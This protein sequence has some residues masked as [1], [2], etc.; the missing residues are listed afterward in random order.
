MNDKDTPAMQRAQKLFRKEEQKKDGALAWNEYASQE[1]A[2]RLKTDRL[3]AL[4]LARDAE[5]AT[6]AP[7]AKPT[8][9]ARGRKASRSAPDKSGGTSA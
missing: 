9:Q 4:R 8:K 7:P 2:T 3:R 5:A 6:A 1:E